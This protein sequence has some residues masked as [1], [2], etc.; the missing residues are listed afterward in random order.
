MKPYQ[1]RSVFLNA[2]PLPVWVTFSKKIDTVAMR[3]PLLAAR[4]CLWFDVVLVVA[5]IA[6]GVRMGVS[7]NG[8]YVKAPGN[9]LLNSIG[10]SIFVLNVPVLASFV[11]CLMSLICAF[12]GEKKGLPVVFSVT[13]VARAILYAMAL[14]SMLFNPGV[15]LRA[16]VS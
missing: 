9:I 3:W 2:F 15:V 1:G 8:G 5:I 10:L 11:G 14:L 7:A 4:A 6:V 13:Q 16:F 12:F